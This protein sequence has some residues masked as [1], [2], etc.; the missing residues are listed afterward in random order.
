MYY[1]E[2]KQFDVANGP[3]VRVSIFVSGCTHRCNGCFNEI[4]WDFNY[5]KPFTD[6][7]I[8]TIMEYLSFPSYAGMTFLGGEPLE[9]SNQIGLLPLARR[10]KQLYPDKTLW[11]Y[12]GYLFDKDIMERMYIDWNETRELMSYI[13][14]LVDGKFVEDLKNL[15]LKFRGS[16]NQRIIMVQESIKTG[17]I[18]LWN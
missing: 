3:G 15:T 2:I 14:V 7:T 6:E 4:A 16:S 9:H 17:K 1:A 5:G 11:C 8:D 10:F 12:T 13:D 18:V